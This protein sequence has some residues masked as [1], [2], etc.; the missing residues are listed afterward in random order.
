MRAALTALEVSS[1]QQ[2]LCPKQL[3][4]PIVPSGRLHTRCNRHLTASRPA[5]STSFIRR[6]SNHA[7]RQRTLPDAAQRQA[8]ERAGTDGLVALGF[9]N[10]AQLLKPALVRSR[11]NCSMDASVDVQRGKVFSYAALH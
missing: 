5:A 3:S 4:V 2:T 10:V 9:E 8:I 6:R 11:S 7:F 1:H